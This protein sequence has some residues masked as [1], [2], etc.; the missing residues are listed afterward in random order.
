VLHA[1]VRVQRGGLAHAAADATCARVLMH[2]VGL[3]G[4]LALRSCDAHCLFWRS[5]LDD[6]AINVVGLRLD[7]VVVATRGALIVLTV[8]ITVGILGIGACGCMDHVIHLLSSV[9]G[10]GM[11]AGA[12]TLGTR[13]VLQKWSGVMV[14]L[15][16]WGFVCMCACAA[17]TIC[18]KS[19]A[20]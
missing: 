4:G 1:R 6:S 9:W 3:V 7:L 17:S 18:C 2:V 19:C 20:V 14:F 8:G 10:M 11:L 16:W 5:R 13:C 15:N 12:F